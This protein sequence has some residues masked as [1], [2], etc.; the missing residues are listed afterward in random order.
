LKI[1]VVGQA[2]FHEEAGGAAR[3]LSGLIGALE[4]AGHDVRVLTSARLLPVRG[5]LGGGRVGKLVRAAVR[6]LAVLP[7]GCWMVVRHRPDVVNVHFA[8]DGLGA[9]AGAALTRRP[10]VATFHGPWA[11]EAAAGEDASRSRATLLRGAIER[12]VYRRAAACVAMSR[13][14]ATILEEDYGV[15]PSRIHVVPLGIELDR[16]PLTARS[17][18]RARLGLPDE[19]TVVSVRR[20]VPRVGLDLAIQALACL[21]RHARPWL[22]IAGNG[23]ERANL[24]RLAE[25][26]GVRDNVRFVGFVPDDLLADVYAAGDACVVPSRALEGF[27]YGAL[28]ALASGTPVVAVRTGGLVELVGALEP[29]W[30]VPWDAAELAVA[31]AG[32]LEAP[33]RFPSRQRCRE[34]AAQFSWPQIAARTVAVYRRAATSRAMIEP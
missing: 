13:A 12:L 8:L 28:E 15:A 21:P 1:V 16:F 20:L 11:R 33:D 34:Y 27:G 23:P 19:P 22:V 6:A 25:R 9:V 17:E 32:V 26:E 3:H 10:L 5:P 14:F 2:E 18:A 31:I 4:R 29:R 7:V 24:E 30:L